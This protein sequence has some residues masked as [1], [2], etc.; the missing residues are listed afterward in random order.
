MA[1]PRKNGERKPCGRLVQQRKLD[2]RYV[3]AEYRTREFGVRGQQI[4]NPLA[5][6]LAGVMFMRGHLEAIHL[7]H[8][9]SF[10]QLS[11]DSMRAAPM[12]ER[13][14]GGRVGTPM[15]L[16]HRYM[17]LARHLGWRMRYL[18]ELARDRLVCPVNTL[19]STLM[20]VPLTRG[21]MAFTNLCETHNPRNAG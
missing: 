14:Q 19:K 16:S 13:V 2:E 12:D 8:F 20:M 18:H 17:T 21:G 9:Y 1:R 3:T 10:L 11:P 4:I 6:Y 5:G 7:G 15:M